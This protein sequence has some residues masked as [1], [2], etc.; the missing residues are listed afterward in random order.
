[1]KMRRDWDDCSVFSLE[2]RHKW[3]YDRHILV[4]ERL[5][6]KLRTGADSVFHVK[7]KVNILKSLKR[8]GAKNVKFC[9][10]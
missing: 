8:W 5:F 10:T 9:L 6:L 3:Q 4:K 1:M 7:S 2:G